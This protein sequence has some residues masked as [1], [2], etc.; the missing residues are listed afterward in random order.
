MIIKEQIIVWKV[1]SNVLHRQISVI[2]TKQAA[3]IQLWD[4]QKQKNYRTKL[5]KQK[6]TSITVDSGKLNNGNESGLF[7]QTKDGIFNL[8]NT[9]TPARR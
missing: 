9:G 1:Q 3:Y 6:N 2:T 7:C 5:Q 8:S 4:L